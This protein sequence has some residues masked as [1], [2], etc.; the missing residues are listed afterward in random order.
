MIKSTYIIPDGTDFK[1]LQSAATRFDNYTEYVV[2][3][4]ISDILVMTMESYHKLWQ[5]YSV[6]NANLYT[7]SQAVIIYTGV[8]KR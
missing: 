4:H 2:R 3:K 6:Y 1:D 7:I 5:K 8:L